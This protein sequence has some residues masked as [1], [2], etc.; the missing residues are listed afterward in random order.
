MKMQKK[1]LD[2]CNELGNS[3]SE[4]VNDF[5][6]TTYSLTIRKR[7]PV[8][9]CKDVSTSTCEGNIYHNIVQTLETT[10]KHQEADHSNASRP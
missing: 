1:F 2:C 7:G 9:M 3:A 5:C 4:L 6:G 10:G 8:V